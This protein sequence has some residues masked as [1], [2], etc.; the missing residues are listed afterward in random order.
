MTRIE[1]GSKKIVSLFIFGSLGLISA[2]LL[3][4]GIPAH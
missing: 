2:A 1:T 4:L 3:V